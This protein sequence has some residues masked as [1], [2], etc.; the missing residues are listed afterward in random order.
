MAMKIHGFWLVET[1]NILV[2][3]HLGFKNQSWKTG[4]KVCTKIH[5]EIGSYAS[6]GWHSKGSD[7]V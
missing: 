3:K 1:K 7:A 6:R 2:L 4:P 5:K